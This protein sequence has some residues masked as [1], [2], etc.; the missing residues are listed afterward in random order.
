M[1]ASLWQL[2]VAFVP[3]T[4]IVVVGICYWATQQVESPPTLIFLPITLIGLCVVIIE[5]CHSGNQS[6][7]VH[8][9]DVLG[10]AQNDLTTEQVNRDELQ[11][12]SDDHSTP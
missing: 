11:V 4:V 8:E 2:T 6:T 3:L 12:S 10:A 9:M 5:W 7:S 1:R